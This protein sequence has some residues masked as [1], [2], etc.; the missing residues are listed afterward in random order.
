LKQLPV[1]KHN[2]NGTMSLT[3]FFK[4]LSLFHIFITF[5]V[6]LYYTSYRF[7]VGLCLIHILLKI[8]LIIIPNIIT[9]KLL[10][11]MLEAWQKSGSFYLDCILPCYDVR[12]CLWITRLVGNMTPGR[13]ARQGQAGCHVPHRSLYHV[14]T[15]LCTL[16]NT[17]FYHTT[18][19]G[20]AFLHSWAPNDH[21]ENVKHESW[22]HSG[23]VFWYGCCVY[24]LFTV[25]VL[26]TAV[27]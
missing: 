27:Y 23:P 14:A 13:R 25:N 6:A 12:L 10:P 17:F 4:L 1:P 7:R 15:L 22:C 8:C 19:V 16:C 18:G 2:N 3:L 26:Y 5:N 24:D 20:C 11:N 21:S 9:I